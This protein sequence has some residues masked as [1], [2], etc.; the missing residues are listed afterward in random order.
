METHYK[1]WSGVM[2]VVDEDVGWLTSGIN[3]GANSA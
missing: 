2:S 1:S 3:E